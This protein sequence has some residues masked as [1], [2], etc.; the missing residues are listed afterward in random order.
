MRP[1]IIAAATVAVLLTAAGQ[2]E[3][4][5]NRSFVSGH[6][7]DS[8]PCNLAGPCRT[9]QQAITQTNA[10]GEIVVLDSAGYGPLTITQ[11]VTITNPG[12]VEA[13]ITA[14]GPN[15]IAILINPSSS[16][17]VTLRGLTLE[18]GGTGLDGIVLS[19]RTQGTLNIIDCVVKDFTNVGILLTPFNST[20]TT[21]FPN[22]LITNSLVL[23]NKGSGIEV[24]PADGNTHLSYSIDHTTVTFNGTSGDDAGILVNQ[25]LGLL[26]G[27]IS[28]VQAHGNNIGINFIGTNAGIL[29]ALIKNSVLTYNSISDL[30]NNSS[31]F[32]VYLFANLIRTLSNAQQINSDGSNDIVLPVQGNALTQVNTRQ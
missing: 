6:G 17:V 24:F 3:A 12:G 8:N 15:Q 18:G 32:S 23:N 7:A 30:T 11:S 21:V 29:E 26:T 13:G 1:F 31:H 14:T 10:G 22:V 19:S 28:S 27:T 20:L 9:F 16:S 4:Q 5:N 25:S 2:A